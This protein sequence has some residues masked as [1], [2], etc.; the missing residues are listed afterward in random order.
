MFTRTATA[1]ACSLLLA[2]SLAAC[3]SE[4]QS[5]AESA[6]CTSIAAVKTAA[7]GVRALSATSTVNDVEAATKALETAVADLRKNAAD[8]NEA[9]LKALE[10]ARDEIR[11]AATS[12]SGN[13][14]L[15]QAATTVKT[16]TG[17]LD[18]AVTEI[19]NGVQCN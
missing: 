10:A 15:G 2:G 6:V 7:D 8:L 12:V 4:S 16:S 19:Q 14:T 5:E 3:G 9:D 18:A 11:Q 1:V 13:D 17:E